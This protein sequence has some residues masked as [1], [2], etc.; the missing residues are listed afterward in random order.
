MIKPYFLTY[1][2]LGDFIDFF[3]LGLITLAFYIKLL[4]AVYGLPLLTLLAYLKLSLLRGTLDK[5][6]SL[7]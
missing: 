3:A 7:D 2:N 5:L 6:D 4:E 1:S